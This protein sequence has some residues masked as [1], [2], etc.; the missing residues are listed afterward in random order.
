MERPGGSGWTRSGNQILAGS[1]S[2]VGFGIDSFIEMAFGAALLWRMSVDADVRRRESN[3]KRALRIVGICFLLL[4]AYLSYESAKDLLLKKAPEHSV[5][6][7]VLACAAVVVMPV[8]SRAKRN[9]GRELGSAAMQADAKQE[10]F[11]AYLSVILLVGLLMNALF[12]LWWADPAGA[13]LMV[14]L[15]ANEGLEAL[16]GKKCGDCDAGAA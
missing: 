14:P 2:L 6:G 8:L 11:C 3:E 5:P 9:V 7:I 12:D 1:V 16:R 4:S 13:L 10:D 15:I